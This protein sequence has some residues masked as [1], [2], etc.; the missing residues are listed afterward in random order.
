MITDRESFEI[1]SKISQNV[2]RQRR[3]TPIPSKAMKTEIATR[4]RSLAWADE[5]PK[6]RPYTSG[7]ATKR[8]TKL[9]HTRPKKL[10]TS[11]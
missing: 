6:A 4:K 7:A 9:V 5:S 1:V 3:I 10:S 8:I 2:Q 11:T